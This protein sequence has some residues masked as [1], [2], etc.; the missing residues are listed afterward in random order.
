MKKF[1]SLVL[2]LVLTVALANTSNVSASK[3]NTSEITPTGTSNNLDVAVIGLEKG[4]SAKL[5]LSIEGAASSD[6]ADF[7]KTIASSGEPII[8]INIPIQLKDGYYQLILEAPDKYFREP[9]GYFFMVRNGVVV[10]T[11]NSALSFTL[12]PP[13]KRD[14]E[15]YRGPTIAPNSDAVIPP[16][17]IPIAG[18]VVYRAE[19]MISLSAPARQGIPEQQVTDDAGYHYFMIDTSTGNKGNWAALGVVNTGIRHNIPDRDHAVDHVYSYR[20]VNGSDHWMEVGWAEVSWQGD[21]RYLYQY[22]SA[23]AQWR[24]L[25]QVSDNS[26]INVAT[27]WLSGT[28]WASLWWNGS[29]WVQVA[30]QDI[31]ISSADNT[32]CGGEVYTYDGNHPDFPTSYTTS[33]YL[34]INGSWDVWDN[35]YFYTTIGYDI[36]PYAHSVITNFYYFS[37]YKE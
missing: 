16:P 25:F 22:D 20:Y 23:Y 5:T 4:E 26:T 28:T 36:S 3:P 21:Y 34:Y 6:I 31:G 1:I 13:D 30:Y 14:Y 27:Q 24:I 9:K 29:T 19:S 10:N 33:N 7:E 32:Y 17:H 18:E 8:K 37:I 12:T 35:D 11:K 2:L 15:P